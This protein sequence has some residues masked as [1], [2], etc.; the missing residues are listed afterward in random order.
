MP[1][2]SNPDPAPHL[3]TSWTFR[4][5]QEKRVTFIFELSEARDVDGIEV[6]PKSQCGGEVLRSKILLVA[7]NVQD[8]SPDARELAV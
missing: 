3:D 4:S 2:K 6:E 8:K 5:D 7:K 1:E